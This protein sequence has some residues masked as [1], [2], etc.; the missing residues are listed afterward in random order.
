MKELDIRVH[1]RY[2]LQHRIG[3]GGFGDVYWAIDVNTGEEVAIKLEHQSIDPSILRQEAEI[4]KSLAGGAGIPSVYW[5]GAQHDYHALVFELLGPSLEDLFNYC[6][7][8]FSL[9]TVLLIMDQ[10]ICRLQYIHSKNVVHRDIK[11]ENFLMGTGRKGNCIYITDL[12]LASEYSNHRAHTGPFPSDPHLLG[13]ARFAS[14]NGHYGIQ[15]QSRRDDM[16]SLGYLFLYFLNGRLPWQGMKAEVGQDNH[17]AVMERKMNIKTEELCG[18]IPREFGTYVDHIRGLK[19]E[20]KPDYSYLRTMFR[21]LFV[22]SGFE[23]DNVFDWTVKK[24][25]EE[26]EI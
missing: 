7:R 8:S 4:Y 12:G 19:F 22:R 2:R 6:G 17:V 23:H 21:N 9:K 5:S 25:I 26:C 13:T 15:R 11:P 20:D 10:L 14:I 16:E 1:D 24:Y 18:G 3:K